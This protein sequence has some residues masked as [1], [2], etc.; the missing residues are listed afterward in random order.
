LKL[1]TKYSAFDGVEFY[2]ETECRNYE[3]K[4]AH[5]RLINLSIEQIEAALSGADPDLADCI[6]RIGAKIGHARR[7]RG[8]LRHQRKAKDAPL[9]PPAF[10]AST[11]R[12]SSESGGGL[13]QNK[14]DAR[15]DEAA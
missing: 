11:A 3:A 8:E 14:P 10:D 7:D 12:P 4:L 6:E 5:V 2:N 9:D 13:S 1:L 15:T